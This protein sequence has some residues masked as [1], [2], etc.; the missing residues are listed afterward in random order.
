MESQ[1]SCMLQLFF[2]LRVC[3]FKVSIWINWLDSASSDPVR[4]LKAAEIMGAD[5]K[6]RK[7]EDA[8]KEH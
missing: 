7:E 2:T 8:G 5:I 4:H 6:N 1:L 3:S